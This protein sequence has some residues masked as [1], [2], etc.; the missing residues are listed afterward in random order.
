MTFRSEKFRRAIAS[1]ACVHCGRVGDTQAAHANL[2]CFGK[3]M[4][5]KA[6]DAAL[7]ALC[8]T[9]HAELDQGKSMTKQE[10]RDFQ[11]ECIS[12]TLVQAVECGRLAP[13]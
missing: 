1:M 12:K 9:C 11:F 7:M 2:S 5:I 13:A 8:T 4:G 3:G 10:R 6:S